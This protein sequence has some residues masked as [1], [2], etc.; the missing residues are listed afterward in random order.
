MKLTKYVAMAIAACCA[1]SAAADEEGPAF[2]AYAG[3]VFKNGYISNGTLIYDDPV[4]Q[5]YA[6][7]TFGDD[8]MGTFDFNFWN[9][10]APKESHYAG[11]AASEIDWEL[12]YGIALGDFKLGFGVATWTYPNTDNWDDEWVG[13]VSV[14]YTGIKDILT[15]E[16]NARFGLESQQGCYGQFKLSRGFALGE[17]TGLSANVYA[18]VG[19]A[20][21]SWRKGKGDDDDGF[22]DFEAGAKISYELCKFASVNVG[23]QYAAIIDSTLR[24]N[25]DTGDFWQADGDADHFMY[26]AGAD[27]WF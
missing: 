15:P 9:S 18:L 22:V 21:K 7:V 11:C 20:S 5:S 17:D 3:T 13:K 16:V 12:D 14:A 8:A 27:I 1:F 6:G 10:C 25:V 19:Y 4:F 2:G 26:Y 24:D 23:C